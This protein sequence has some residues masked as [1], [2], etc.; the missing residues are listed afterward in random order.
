[1]NIANYRFLFVKISLNETTRQLIAQTGKAQASLSSRILKLQPFS[2][3]TIS[4]VM[5][6]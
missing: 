4:V 2:I 3:P 5:I 6:P 1:M